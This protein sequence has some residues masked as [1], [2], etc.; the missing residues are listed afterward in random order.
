MIP[1]SQHPEWVEHKPSIIERLGRPVATKAGKPF[2]F[3]FWL[4]ENK[5]GNT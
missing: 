5:A 3:L 1:D 4:K 2:F